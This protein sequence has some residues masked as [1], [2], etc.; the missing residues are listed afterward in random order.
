MR[1][2]CCQRCRD[3]QV[4]LTQILWNIVIELTKYI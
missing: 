3:F 2:F 1:E 4:G